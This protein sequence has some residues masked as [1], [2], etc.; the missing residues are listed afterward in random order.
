MKFLF[1][2][3]V[4]GV[5]LLLT[6]ISM[7]QLYGRSPYIRDFT[8][9]NDSEVEFSEPVFDTSYIYQEHWYLNSKY[10]EYVIALE[11]DDLRYRYFP[12]K[13][14]PRMFV[15]LSYGPIPHLYHEYYAPKI[16]TSEYIYDD[17]KYCEVPVDVHLHLTEEGGVEIELWRVD[18][19]SRTPIAV[20]VNK[21]Y[22][23]LPEMAICVE[24][25][26]DQ[27]DLWLRAQV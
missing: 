19:Y 26:Y 17:E 7:S 25:I 24:G 20:Q 18:N 14:T 3:R 9:T 10:G 21:N 15:Y 6:L 2:R 12:T 22:R 11:F 16:A 27:T 8:I 5:A 4:L 1:F 23:I 13:Y